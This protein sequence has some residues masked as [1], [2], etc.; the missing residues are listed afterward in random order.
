MMAATRRFV[1]LASLLLATSPIAASASPPTNIMLDLPFGPNQT[2]SSPALHSFGKDVVAVWARSRFT[3][4]AG[5]AEN[6]I[7][8]DVSNDSG[9]TFSS[10]VDLPIPVT[11][12]NWRWNRE[13]QVAM[14]PDNHAILIVGLVSTTS[15]TLHTGVG[16]IR[17]VVSSGTV[18]WNTPSI[19]TQPGPST[20]LIGTLA[21][22]FARAD[23]SLHLLMLDGPTNTIV[24]MRSPDGTG[25]TWTAPVAI[26]DPI[27]D[28]SPLYLRLAIASTPS[29]TE[30]H[31]AWISSPGLNLEHVNYRKSTDLGVT[32]QPEQTPASIRMNPVMP[33]N[34]GLLFTPH[35]LEPGLSLAVNSCTASP[36]FGRVAMAWSESWDFSDEPFPALTSTLFRTE[37]EPN[38]VAGQAMAFNPGDALQGTFS[39][40]SDVDFWKV[41][42]NAGDALLLWADSTTTTSLAG[43]AILDVDGT[44]VIQNGPW[45][46]PGQGPATTMAFRAPVAG[47]YYVRATRQVGTGA[48][49]YYRIRTR[50]GAPG[51]GEARDAQDVTVIHSTPSGWSSPVRALMS[52]AGYV[53]VQPTIG[54][55]ADGLDYVTWYD[56]YAGGANGARS[57]LVAARNLTGD[58]PV[59]S[60]EQ[61]VSDAI[62]DWNNGIVIV[63]P[64]IGP[65][66]GVTSDDR[67]VGLAWVD[68]RDGYQNAQAITV[69]TDA[70]LTSFPSD[71]NAAAG[72]IATFRAGLLNRNPL[73]DERTLVTVSGA[74]GWPVGLIARDSVPAGSSGPLLIHVPV[75]DTAAAGV[76][77]F[78]LTFR[79]QS[80]ILLGQ[81]VANLTIAPVT[82]V[83]EGRE[84]F[85][86]EA[87]APNPT[88]GFTQVSFVL[89]RAAE[90]R[91]A[92]YGVTGNRV[93]TL[94]SG[95]SGAGLHQL[96]W[97][98]RDSEGRPSPPGLYLIRVE[99]MGRSMA[100]RL[101]LL[102]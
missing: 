101:A 69:A 28:V 34:M 45:G 94:A 12:V 77:P 79:R 36:A 56:M 11:T 44:S 38:D 19:V 72:G 43:T 2:C 62:S 42:M 21:L 51:A 64:G 16:L 74:R 54:F 48:G 100:K 5:N 8:Y 14:D 76:C 60:S 50:W 84:A 59:V 57:H 68:F 63:P 61:I 25:A 70:F 13:P 98:G 20:N 30:L 24:Y 39:T 33:G 85:K 66:N 1:A 17:G 99:S 32:W 93:R 23:H 96:T 58:D 3:G 47:T 29:A 86:I 97:D 90:A 65:S 18:I 95:M 31:A 92:I 82:G 71:T 10:P 87:L 78:T 75:P 52:P 83:V 88:R 46:D 7:F 37:V 22:A 102:R 89:P 27:N 55:G 91:V 81:S 15:G 4:L 26:S 41:P 73:F 40:V 9:A 67:R 49:T 35:Q 6:R 80:G 53:D